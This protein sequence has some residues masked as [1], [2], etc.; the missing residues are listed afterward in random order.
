MSL[1]ASLKRFV[2]QTSRH[3]FAPF[4][5]VLNISEK[6]T[7]KILVYALFFLKNIVY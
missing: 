7:K 4:L 5:E 3:F 2:E 6:F 1:P